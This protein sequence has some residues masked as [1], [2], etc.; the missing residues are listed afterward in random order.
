MDSLERSTAANQI[1]NAKYALRRLL[2]EKEKK[3]RNESDT[4]YHKRNTS[5]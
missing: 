3:L 2:S 5:E 4:E 1:F